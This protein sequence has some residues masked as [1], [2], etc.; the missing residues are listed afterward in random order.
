MFWLGSHPEFHSSWTHLFF[1]VK[2][3]SLKTSESIKIKGGFKT[4][5]IYNSEIQKNEQDVA[6]DPQSVVVV[7]ERTWM[8]VL[9]GDGIIMLWSNI[10]FLS[11]CH[12]LGCQGTQISI[13]EVGQAFAYFTFFWV[14]AQSNLGVAYMYFLLFCFLIALFMISFISQVSSNLM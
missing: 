14:S 13:K 9:R 3:T 7:A 2:H 1:W 5:H 12:L 6:G 8:W 11:C 10:G 4:D